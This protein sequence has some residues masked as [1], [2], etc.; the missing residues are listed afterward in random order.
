M[1]CARCGKDLGEEQA[2]NQCDWSVDEIDRPLEHSAPAQTGNGQ[3]IASLCCGIF[4]WFACGGFV[5]IPAIGLILGIRAM[6]SEQQGI[7][8]VGVILNAVILILSVLTIILIGIAACVTVE[9]V[10]SGI[11]TG[12][13]C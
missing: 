7:A 9:Q 10:P 11:P 4:S 13:C 1:F 5:V 12:R 2:C 6:K 8:L 3:A